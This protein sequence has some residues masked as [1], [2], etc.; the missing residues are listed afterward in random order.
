MRL[1]LPQLPC[2]GFG[3]LVQRG[4]GGPGW[5][6]GEAHGAAAF[7]LLRGLG[8]NVQLHTCPGQHLWLGL[9]QSSPSVQLPI[10]PVTSQEFYSFVQIILWSSGH[11]GVC[12]AFLSA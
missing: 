6:G 11:G 2:R 8:K 5:L 9:S 1:C 12:P 7:S 4:C 10:L 3:E